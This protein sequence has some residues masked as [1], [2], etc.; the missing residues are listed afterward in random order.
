M[1]DGADSGEGEVAWD[2]ALDSD[3]SDIQV[4]VDLD[5]LADIM[6]TSGTTGLP[7]GVA[8]RH[9]NVAMIPNHEP[10]W[11]GTGGLHGAPLF[12]FAGISFI[13]NPMKMGMVGLYFPKFDA[14]EWLRIVARATGHGVPRAR[15]GRAA[16]RPSGLQLQTR[17]PAGGLDRQRSSR[18]TR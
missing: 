6:Y 10:P 12:T 13:Y 18:R 11:T 4:D 16:R 14:G 2:E 17:Q 5:D 9:R 7:K 15:H 1:S 3:D 8:V